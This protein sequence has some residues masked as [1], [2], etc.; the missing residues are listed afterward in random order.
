MSRGAILLVAIMLFTACNAH[1]QTAKQ[2]SGPELIE[3]SRKLTAVDK[4]GCL[5]PD[6]GPAIVVC[7]ESEDTKSQRIFRDQ[8]S[9]PRHPNGAAQNT[10]AAAC[11]PGT[12]C[13]PRMKGGVS[14]GF[15]KVPPPAIPFEEVLRGLPE[16]EDVVQEGE[17]QSSTEKTEAPQ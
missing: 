10:A 14:I 3:R 13:I 7:G 11:I 12:G 1:A 4:N 16:P 8:L 9:D 6:D 17:E 5:K 2:Q 15:G